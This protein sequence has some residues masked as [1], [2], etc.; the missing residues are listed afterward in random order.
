[1]DL[2]GNIS[3][4]SIEKKPSNLEADQNSLLEPVTTTIVY[5]I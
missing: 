3:L 4:A 1:M 2:Q 5:S